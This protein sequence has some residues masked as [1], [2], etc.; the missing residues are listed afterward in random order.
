M[1]TVAALY[2][3]PRGP[4]PKLE[5]VECW[6]AVRDARLYD[7]PH[8]VVAH[9]PCKNYSRISY[10]AK[11][12]ERDCAIRAVVQVRRWGGVLEHPAHSRLFNR[13]VPGYLPWPGDL[14]D[15]WGGITIAV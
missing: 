3:D 2:I 15:P 14:P 6:D 7:G 12:D 11:G 8:P 5:G 4:Y 10:L 9:P 1:L 13:M